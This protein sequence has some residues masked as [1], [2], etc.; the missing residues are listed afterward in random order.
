MG[1][2]YAKMHDSCKK[3]HELDQYHMILIKYLC[4]IVVLGKL[5]IIYS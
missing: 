4:N 1:E 5:A 2:Y 3:I